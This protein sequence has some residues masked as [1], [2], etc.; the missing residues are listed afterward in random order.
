MLAT[1]GG[2]G[3]GHGGEH[4]Y[5]DYWT[6]MMFGFLLFCVICIFFWWEGVCVYYVDWEFCIWY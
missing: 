2:G 4:F 6:V 1:D 3:W 5:V